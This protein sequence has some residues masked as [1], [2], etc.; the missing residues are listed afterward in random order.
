MIEESG[1]DSDDVRPL[2]VIHPNPAIQG[3]RCHTFVAHGVRRCVQ[4]KFDSTEETEVA[5]VPLANIPELI[6]DGTIGHALVVVAFHWL[7]LRS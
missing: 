6:R 7:G 5:L 1:Y 4:P 3:N 2:G